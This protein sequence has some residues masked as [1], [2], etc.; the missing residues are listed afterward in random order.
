ML[1]NAITRTGSEVNSA[2]LVNNTKQSD[3]GTQK[4]SPREVVSRKFKLQREA[5]KLLPDKRVSVCNR[6]VRACEIGEVVGR[7]VN[8]RAEFVNVLRCASVWD[9]PV[10]ASKIA[11]SRSRLVLSAMDRA[12]AL[13]YQVHL[14]TLTVPHTIHQSAKT[15]VSALS[16]ARSHWKDSRAYKAHKA[17]SGWLGEIWANEVTYGANGWHAHC[18]AMVFSKSPNLEA[19]RSQWTASVLKQGLGEVN[20]RGFDVRSYDGAKDY[21]GKWGLEL[22]LTRGDLKKSR[23]GGSTPFYLLEQSMKG[24]QKAGQ[25]FV[26]YSRAFHGRPQLLWTDGLKKAL[27]VDDLD[28]TQLAE[29]L[30]VDP[31]LPHETWVL[32]QASW[33]VVLGANMRGELLYYAGRYGQVGVDALVA[34]LKGLE[35]IDEPYYRQ[36]AR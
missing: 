32:D 20:R 21:V 12:L 1:V 4:P 18:H 5:Q 28:D 6:H 23:K 16:S 31:M 15:V 7:S 19:L 13:G 17:A 10:C 24:D 22:E 36:T 3:A 29:S 14:L 11:S 35:H 34:K 26:E 2:S 33:M 30:E 25:L 8:G 27:L 9:C